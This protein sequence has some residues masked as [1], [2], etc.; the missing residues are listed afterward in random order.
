MLQFQGSGHELYGGFPGYGP[1]LVNASAM[2]Q[3]MPATGLVGHGGL[4]P[5]NISPGSIGPGSL[6]PGALG[7][8]S[9][10]GQGI[11]PHY[12]GSYHPSYMQQ[13]I[14]VC[15]ITKNITSFYSNF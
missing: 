13:S 4:G 9:M 7:P 3:A 15:K 11:P 6:S 1:M 5:G 2:E 14:Q 12:N 10:M 8:G